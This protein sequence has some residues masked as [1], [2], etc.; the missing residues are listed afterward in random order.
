MTN[1]LGQEGAYKRTVGRFYV[2]VVQ[3]VLLF[4]S[5]T[6]VLI[7][8]LEKYL[9]RFHHWAARRMEDMVTKCHREGT[10]LYLPIGAALAMVGI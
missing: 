2:A 10:W 8:R 3:A 6:W 7:P 9:E 1:I 5:E 4:G